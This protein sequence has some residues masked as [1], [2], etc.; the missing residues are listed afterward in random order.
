MADYVLAFLGGLAG[1]LVLMIVGMALQAW[2]LN[3]CNLADLIFDTFAMVP[4]PVPMLRDVGL[5]SDWV[6]L[7]RLGMPTDTKIAE[8]PPDVQAKVIDLAEAVTHEGARLVVRGLLRYYEAHYENASTIQSQRFKP[9]RSLF[10]LT[11]RGLAEVLRRRSKLP[12][13]AKPNEVQA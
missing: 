1:L 3:R 6:A 7:K 4:V 5:D 8:L 12:P 11:Q 9:P 2:L 10:L 13:A